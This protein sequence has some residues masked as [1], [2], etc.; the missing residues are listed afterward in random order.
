M[1]RRKLPVDAFAIYLAQGPGRS[2]AAIAKQFKVAKRTVARTAQVE[3]WQSRVEERERKQREVAE[4][5]AIE[6]A[7]EM[8]DRHLK[9]ARVLQARGLEALRTLQLR[10]AMDAV[11]T[12]DVGVR[13]ERE[14]RGNAR[15]IVEREEGLAEMRRLFA[16]A[17]DSGTF[18]GAVILEQVPNNGTEEKE[19]S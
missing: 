18:S 5:E 13:Q 15:E 7:T 11:K 3:R 8:R 9:V 4:R 16:L 12:I 6:S 10:S 17:V 14:L 2:Y 1:S 19:K